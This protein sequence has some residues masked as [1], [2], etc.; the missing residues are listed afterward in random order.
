M[1]INTAR[2]HARVR[3]IDHLESAQRLLDEAIIL[4]DEIRGKLVRIAQLTGIKI[5]QY[6]DLDDVGDIVEMVRE[7]E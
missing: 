3:Q 5:N 6:Q 4:Q 1:G 7:G 2:Q